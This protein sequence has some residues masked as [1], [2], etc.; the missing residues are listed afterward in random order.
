MFNSIQNAVLILTLGLTS[1]LALAQTKEKGLLIDRVN[2]QEQLAFQYAKCVRSLIENSNA[3]SDFHIQ[4][5]SKLI[6][7]SQA[8]PSEKSLEDGLS[9]C[10]T[11]LKTLGPSKRMTGA[12]T[13]KI[14]EDLTTASQN[15]LIKETSFVVIKR[16]LYPRKKCISV[17]GS[18][19]F[20]LAV[21]AQLGAGANYCVFENGRRML[22]PNA[23]VAFGMGMGLGGQLG[24]G[25]SQSKSSTPKPA[26]IYLAV[27]GEAGMWSPLK[28]YWN[29]PSSAGV[30][31]LNPNADYLY[32]FSDGSHNLKG[33]A[34]IAS[35]V[36]L[37]VSAKAAVGWNFILQ[38]DSKTLI[39]AMGPS[40]VEMSLF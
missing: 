10:K 21:S 36:Q 28:Y 38:D 29:K 14:Y 39:T 17:D 1:N 5:T 33:R 16:F 19:F 15:G 30:V 27:G 7:D 2:N 40:D 13:E 34:T 11:E 8:N 20:G 6:D 32:D 23:M 22:T 4:F 37:T 35:I 24:I 26:N 31:S 18:M 12:Q 9:E 3:T 25:Y